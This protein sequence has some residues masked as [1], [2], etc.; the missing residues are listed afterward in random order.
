MRRRIAARDGSEVKEGFEKR[1]AIG[2]SGCASIT[3]KAAF[4]ASQRLIQ[5]Q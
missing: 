1:K 3:G 2:A 4:Q 5:Y